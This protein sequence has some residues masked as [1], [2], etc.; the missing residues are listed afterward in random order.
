MRRRIVS[1]FINAPT[2]RFRFPRASIFRRPA[3]PDPFAANVLQLIIDNGR[4]TGVAKTQQ[5]DNPDT[6]PDD[7]GLRYAQVVGR[8]A[9]N[10]A[11]IDTP[12]KKTI[13]TL[14]VDK[15]RTRASTLVGKNC[16]FWH[17]FF[18]VPTCLGLDKTT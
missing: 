2:A 6:I 12:K 3:V 8:G 17:N 10:N 13:A 9:K 1:F 7:H 18:F 11:Q 4:K 15:I 14:L 16:V 5:T